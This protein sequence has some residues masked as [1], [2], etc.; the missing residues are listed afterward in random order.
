VLIATNHSAIAK[1][2][3]DFSLIFSV[4]NQTDRL[5]ECYQGAHVSLL[6]RYCHFD[7]SVTDVMSNRCSERTRFRKFS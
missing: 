6:D 3:D 2:I 1:I 7:S 4:I 5:P